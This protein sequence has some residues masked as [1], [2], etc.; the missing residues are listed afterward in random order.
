MLN[1]KNIKK[2]TLEEL[3]EKLGIT[4]YLVYCLKKQ[5]IITVQ[6]F[7]VA[8]TKN[9]ID[10]V[11]A[12]GKTKYDKIC[13]VL[14]NY[15]IIIPEPIK[16]NKIVKLIEQI[17]GIENIS[18]YTRNYI[19]YKYNLSEI[20]LI[21]LEN[22]IS[23]YNL[24]LKKHDII[25]EGIKKNTAVILYANNIYTVSQLEK[26]YHKGEVTEIRGIGEKRL[27]E[28]ENFLLI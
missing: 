28:I 3:K 26:A 20:D 2:M 19:I 17:D 18:L 14:S 15:G 11:E 1:E 9:R 4:R 21:E 7:I 6:D 23:K 16:S 27:K 5:E 13:K 8:V 10:K 25:D 12:L 22:I 24:S